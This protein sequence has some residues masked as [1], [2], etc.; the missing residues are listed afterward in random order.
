MP[1][2]KKDTAGAGHNSD[3]V[4]TDDD[5]AALQHYHAVKIFQLQKAA[6]EAQTVY[7][8]KLALVN[9]QFA[10]V[11][12]DLRY[13]R[14]DMEDLLEK[15]RMTPAE[16]AIQEAQ[17]TKRYTLAG[18]REGET[19]SL[20]FDTVD[21]AIAA[22]EDGYRAGRRADD[23][24]PP[25]RIAAVLHPDWLRGWHRGQE[26]NGKDFIRANELI[27]A[28]KQQGV[29]LEAEA[30]TQGEAGDEEHPDD[31]IEDA[32][33]A[34]KAAGWTKPTE[35]ERSFAGA[36]DQGDDADQAGAERQKVDA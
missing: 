24:V 14:K 25:E 2:A 36:D 23:P 31:V 6:E 7:K 4:L 22:E 16:F 9:D 8:G 20:D 10:L 28:R 17:R 5:I 15:L 19:G 12:S 13:T 27:E 35:E 11:K 3:V 34:L 18:L 33:D 26:D 1:R 29:E 32:A 30:E 21:E